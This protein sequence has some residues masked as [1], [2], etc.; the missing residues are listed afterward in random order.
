MVHDDERHEP[1]GREDPERAARRGEEHEDRSGADRARLLRAVEQREEDRTAREPEQED[2]QAEEESRRD[3]VAEVREPDAPEGAADAADAPPIPSVRETLSSASDGIASDH[4]TYSQRE[5]HGED[6]HPGADHPE[7]DGEPARHD[8]PQVVEPAERREHQ[9]GDA[10][11]QGGEHRRSGRREDRDLRAPAPRDSDEVGEHHAD[12]CAHGRMATERRA[13]G[14]V[15]V[16]R[17]GHD[18]HDADERRPEREEQEA[19]EAQR[20]VRDGGVDHRSAPARG[21]G[22]HQEPAS[23]GSEDRAAE[24]GGHDPVDRVA[25]PVPEGETGRLAQRDARPSAALLVVGRSR[26]G[27]VPGRT[28]GRFGM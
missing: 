19:A 2:E 15:G 11:D 14:E 5:D 12:D 9:R 24:E 23:G 4:R 28:H 13:G 17:R 21:E 25:P 22:P 1:C 26:R 18:D 6:R 8:V 10:G 3:V 20:E 16:A 27:T 7:R